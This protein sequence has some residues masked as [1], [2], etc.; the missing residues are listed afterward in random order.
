MHGETLKNGLSCLVLNL[1]VH[2]VTT[3]LLRFKKL[4]VED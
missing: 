4:S 1:M 2:K 3:R